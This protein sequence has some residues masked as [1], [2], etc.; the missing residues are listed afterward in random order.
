[1]IIGRCNV[2]RYK[3]SPIHREELRIVRKSSNPTLD[4]FKLVL[5]VVFLAELVLL[6]LAIIFGKVIGYDLTL[7]A[8]FW[9]GIIVAG[10]FAFIIVGNLLV[11][12]AVK[13]FKVLRKRISIR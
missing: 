3:V 6:L 12:A 13:V 5:F 9:L 7:R 2:K 10:C 1:V 4:Y 11:I 8:S